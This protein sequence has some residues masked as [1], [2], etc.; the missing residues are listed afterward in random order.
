MRPQGWTAHL[1]SILRMPHAL[2][3]S[4]CGFACMPQG[5]AMWYVLHAAGG[6]ETAQL[7]TGFKRLCSKIYSYSKAY[8]SNMP[9]FIVQF[10]I[11][12]PP[13]GPTSRYSNTLSTRVLV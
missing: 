6:D 4:M 1:M 8:L 7:Q 13:I 9:Y 5:D 3:R 12:Y 11:Y 10:L 2:K